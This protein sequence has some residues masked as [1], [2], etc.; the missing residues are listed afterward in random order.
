MEQRSAEIVAPPQKWRQCNGQQLRKL[1]HA[2]LIWLEKNH[3]QVNA[4]NV[5]PVPDGDTGT[6]ML[7]TMRS[8][9]ARIESSAENGISAVAHDLAHGALMGARGNSGVI[10]SQIWRGL[11]RGLKDK[12]TANVR[13]LALA[14]KV[15]SDTAYKG[16]MRPVEGTILTVIREGSEEAQHAAENSIDM[17]FLLE[18]VLERCQQAL[19]RTPE[20]LPVLAQ[21]GV[22]DSGGQGLVFILEGM[23]RYVN[24]QMDG[25]ASA[26]VLPRH[27]PAQ[28]HAVPDGGVLENPYDVQFILMG[29]NLNVESIRDTIDAMGDSTVVVGDETTIKV[30][31]HVKD[32]GQPISF[33][34]SMGVITDVVV[35]NMQMQM[36]EIVTPAGINSVPAPALAS[37][38][39]ERPKLRPDQ[40]GVVAVA[41]GDGLAEIFRSL[42]VAAIVPG[43][44]THNPSTE[45]ILQAIEQLET[46]KVIILP[47]N[48]NIILAA[49]AALELC[50]RQVGIVPTR[51]TPQG[52]SAMLAWNADGD[53]R[54]TV[55][56]MTR[57]SKQVQSG[58][59]TTATRTVTL[60]GVEV[61]AGQIIGLADGKICAAGR[62]LS[63]VLTRTLGD[64]GVDEGEIL[65]IYYGQDVDPEEAQ[66]LADQLA[67]RYPDLEVELYNGG[68]P[69]FYY[70]LGLE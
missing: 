5:F 52:M 31:V 6:N 69:H 40:I 27:L 59:I 37:L 13:D 61:E 3:Q 54:E 9:Y 19:E 30:H 51:T 46:E 1:V 21:A 53:L 50:D 33:G 32:P 34:I 68:Q 55:Q 7:L 23:L 48:K 64:M 11:A 2:G 22:V 66:A 29:Q 70:V 14:L 10:L 35:E 44:Q 12:E 49:E 15:A 36:E 24:G 63:D 28:A 56:A 8:A 18:R 47:N 58:E 43:G 25:L 65:S 60:D 20:L 41:A 38:V 67:T 62:D 57:N 42:G 26:G 39:E 17:R 45:E 16:V 4:L